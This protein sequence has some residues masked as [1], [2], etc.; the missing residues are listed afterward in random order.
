MNLTL[1][2][3]FLGETYTIGSLFINGEYFSDTLEDRVRPKGVKV[4]NETAIPYGTY[5]VIVNMSPKF[6]R[7]LPRLLNVPG[8]D[9]ILIH[10][11]NTIKDT[12][13][14]ILPGE[15]RIKGQVVNST[16]YEQE[17]V[18]QMKKALNKGE[19]I[20]ITIE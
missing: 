20:S 18:I 8:F 17:L 9:G 5:D 6:R 1:K 19:K 2:R 12:S 10:R 4:K 15:N 13:G 16:P 14:C 3:R 7:E 11:G